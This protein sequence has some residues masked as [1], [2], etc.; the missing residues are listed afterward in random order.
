MII[1]VVLVILK[2]QS[3]NMLA[4]RW[5]TEADLMHSEEKVNFE[6][7][8]KISTELPP[9]LTAT[10]LTTVLRTLATAG[11]HFASPENAPTLEAREGTLQKRP[12][13]LTGFEL[14]AQS[15]PVA[16]SFRDPLFKIHG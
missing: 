14:T 12:S 16:L 11:G 5:K 13:R 7:T 8:Y 2:V 6:P 9:N 10:L 4:N 3:F 1:V 15:Q